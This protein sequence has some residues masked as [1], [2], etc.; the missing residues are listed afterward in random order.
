[1]RRAVV[2]TQLCGRGRSARCFEKY[3]A[4]LGGL[5]RPECRRRIR[6]RG[7]GSAGPHPVGF[8]MILHTFERAE[9]AKKMAVSSG[10]VKK[11]LQCVASQL[12]THNLSMSEL[13]GQRD[14]KERGRYGPLAPLGSNNPL[15][16]SGDGHIF[17]TV[18]FV[19]YR[20]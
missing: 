2:G 13:G 12:R 5:W 15:T 14:K 3:R 20:S 6:L 18:M 4:K 8:R 10:A 1:L 19:G 17:Q 11:T 9:T 16:T 7:T